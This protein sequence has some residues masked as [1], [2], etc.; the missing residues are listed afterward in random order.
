[1]KPDTFSSIPLSSLPERQQKI[2]QWWKSRD[3][4]SSFVTPFV[5]NWLDARSLSNDWEKEYVLALEYLIAYGTER[6]KDREGFITAVTRW[7]H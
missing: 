7:M 5:L 6:D 1:M 3:L 2:A 4:S